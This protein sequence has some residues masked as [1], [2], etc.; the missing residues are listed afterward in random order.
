MPRPPPPATALIMTAPPAPS[1]ARNA[2]VSSSVVGPLVPSI[3][4]KPQRL[5][6]RLA[7][8]LSP[9]RSSASGDGPT[10]TILSSAQRRA[11]CEFS[12]RKP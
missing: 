6:S 11:S 4:G 5:A 9:N 7:A 12:L 10:K 8:I 3:T 2:L 1:E